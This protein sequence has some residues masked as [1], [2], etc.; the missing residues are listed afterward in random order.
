MKKSYRKDAILRIKYPTE[1]FK[2]CYFADPE[3][4]KLKE[5]VEIADNFYCINKTFTSFR[6]LATSIGEVPSKMRKADLLDAIQTEL[7]YLKE[8]CK[9]CGGTDN[10]YI[11]MAMVEYYLPYLNACEECGTF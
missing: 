11:T 9:Y 5:L 1:I 7:W 8:V 6:K 4:F 2:R 3:D 10:G